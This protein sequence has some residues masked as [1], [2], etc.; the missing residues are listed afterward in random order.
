MSLSYMKPRTRDSPSSTKVVAGN[1]PCRSKDSFVCT[2]FS[3]LFVS[4][5]ASTAHFCSQ[6]KKERKKK[7]RKKNDTKIYFMIGCLCNNISYG[8]ESWSLSLIEEYN[9]KVLKN[10]L[11]KTGERNTLRLHQ[12]L[13]LLRSVK[14]ITKLKNLNKIGKES[15][16]SSVMER[17]NLD[18]KPYIGV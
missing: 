1:T 7:K 10:V 13:C 15:W 3:S 2:M 16:C 18:D 11:K 17:E 8:C 5:T 14:I 4:V 12:L 9:L 6:E